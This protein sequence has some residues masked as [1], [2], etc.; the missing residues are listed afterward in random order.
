MA[1]MRIYG[2]ARISTSDQNL[3]LQTQALK[4]SGVQEVITEIATGKSM[5]RQQLKLLLDKL[6]KGNTLLVYRL[7]RLGVSLI[8][9]NL[10]AV[11]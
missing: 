4:A 5:E 10:H 2:C 7:D 8:E 11:F 9:R 1:K 6:Q 3:S